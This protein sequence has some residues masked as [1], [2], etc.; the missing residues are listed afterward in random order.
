MQCLLAGLRWSISLALPCFGVSRSSAPGVSGYLISPD[1]QL[2]IP[3]KAG[4]QSLLLLDSAKS[5]SQSLDSRQKHA[6]MT[7][8][9]HSSPSVQL[10]IE[11]NQVGLL[12]A[13]LVFV[14]RFRLALG[15]VIAFAAVYVPVFPVVWAQQ[16]IAMVGAVVVVFFVG[17]LSIKSRGEV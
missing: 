14:G 17:Y 6:G 9:S 2:V 3:A 8:Q 4:I 15:A 5:R 11:A 13:W 1:P 16:T 7:S 10:R 12:A